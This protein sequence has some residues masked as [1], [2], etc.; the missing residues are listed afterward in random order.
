MFI[1]HKIIH[2]NTLFTYKNFHLLLFP[3]K[4]WVF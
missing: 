1:H 2:F 3:N 4:L